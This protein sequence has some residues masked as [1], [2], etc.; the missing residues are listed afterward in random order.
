MNDRPITET[1]RALRAVFPALPLKDAA[2]AA[3]DMRAA[4]RAAVARGESR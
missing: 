1:V 4:E 2:R 3:F